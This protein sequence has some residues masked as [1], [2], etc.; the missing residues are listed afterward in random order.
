MLQGHWYSKYKAHL[1]SI[2]QN[3][4]ERGKCTTVWPEPIW[5]KMRSWWQVLPQHQSTY[6]RGPESAGIRPKFTLLKV[7]LNVSVVKWYLLHKKT[8]FLE[9]SW[10]KVWKGRFQLMQILGLLGMYLDA[11]VVFVTNSSLFF[12]LALAILWYP[13]PIEVLLSCLLRKLR[14]SSEIVKTQKINKKLVD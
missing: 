7:P 2:I 5:I 3:L 8:S 13:I 12:R 1:P 10:S 14:R 11:V 9:I 4:N 6:L